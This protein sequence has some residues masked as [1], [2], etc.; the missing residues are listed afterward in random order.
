MLK[1]LRVTYQIEAAALMKPIFHAVVPLVGLAICG[2]SMLAQANERV[3]WAV[4]AGGPHPDYPWQLTVDADKNVYVV[5]ATGGLVSYGPSWIGDSL[6]FGTCFVAKAD[7]AGNW[8]WATSAGVAEAPQGRF[9]SLTVDHD[10]NIYAAG[11]VEGAITWGRFRLTS[12][13]GHNHCLVKLDRQ[14][15]VLWAKNYGGDFDLEAL[16]VAT[17]PDGS[18]VVAG[19][20]NLSGTIDQNTNNPGRPFLG[21]VDA[22]GN[23]LWVRN[24][25]GA[26]VNSV[27]ATPG[28]EIVVVGAFATPVRFGTFDLSRVEDGG[29]S[30]YVVATD[31]NGNFR[32]A[33]QGSSV[34]AFP[35]AVQADHQ[36]NAYVCGEFMQSIVF[37][38]IGLTNAGP[39][40][41]GFLVKF[42][43]AGHT[44]WASQFETGVGSIAVDGNGFVYLTGGLRRRCEIRANEVDRSRVARRFSGPI[45]SGWRLLQ[46]AT[47]W[48]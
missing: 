6:P 20:L 42:D 9:T 36:G 11:S 41:Q 40:L 13:F 8:L 1:S 31:A 37:D 44:L 38:Q 4:R 22:D 25:E 34:F 27:T 47:V 46:R 29:L 10:G 33:K 14:G 23:F 17:H 24:A 35:S 39:E 21:K 32:W 3:V 18:L 48:R 30:V 45:G 28:G 7:P 5:A 15:N 26:G 43:A 12:G 19:G 2:C 16:S